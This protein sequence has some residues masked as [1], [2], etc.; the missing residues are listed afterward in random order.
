M[1]C[2]LI[3]QF[4]AAMALHNYRLQ[5]AVRCAPPLMLSVRPHGKSDPS[6]R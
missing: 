6:P 1:F 5:R 2:T 4:N 3:L